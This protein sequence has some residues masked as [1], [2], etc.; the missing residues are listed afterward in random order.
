MRYVVG[1]DEVGRGPLAGPV[2]V[3]ALA[4]PEHFYK[5]LSGQFDSKKLTHKTREVLSR[6]LRKMRSEGLI[7]YKIASVSHEVIDKKGIV[8]AVTKAISF[9]LDRLNVS[10][11]LSLVLLDGGLRAPKIYKNQKTII[12]GDSSVPLIGLASVL[13]KVHRDKKM[14][15]LAREY[16]EYGFDIHKGYGTRAH[17]NALKKH[18]P[19][20]IHRRSYIKRL[21][22]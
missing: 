5:T 19:S 6:D 3:C 18:G 12:K 11:Q 1:I 10:S 21:I 2:T 7:L 9:S 15:R 13:A 4:V 22:K 8:H 17:Y 16:P 14:A 20:K